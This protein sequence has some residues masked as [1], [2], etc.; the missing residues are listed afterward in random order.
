LLSAV[1]LASCSLDERTLVPIDSNCTGS[2]CGG[3]SGGNSGA[4]GGSSGASPGRGGSG[5]A[6]AGEGGQID[7]GPTVDCVDLDQNTIPD[8]SETVVANAGFDRDTKG[9]SPE[10]NGAIS[11]DSL[12]ARGSTLSGTLLVENRSTGMAQDGGLVYSGATQCV[13]IEPN[14]AYDLYA[15]MYSRGPV[16]TGYASVIGRVFASADCSGSPLRVETSPIQGTINLWITLQA[17]IP[18]M[19]GA[20][21]LMVELSVGRLSSKPGPVSLT[22]DNVLL[23]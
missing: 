18:A 8:C 17:T 20:Q 5:G 2:D 12:D 16:I 22:F 7:V 10:A 9:W 19:T 13:P 21:S 11:W 6:S 4:R 1:S 15:Q 14:H 23:R 3:S